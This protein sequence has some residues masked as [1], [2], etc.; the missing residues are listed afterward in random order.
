MITKIKLFVCLLLFYPLTF[1][2]NKFQPA[3]FSKHYSQLKPSFWAV[4][5]KQAHLSFDFFVIVKSHFEPTQEEALGQVQKQ[6]A[7]LFGTLDRQVKRAVPKNNHTVK[8]TKVEKLAQKTFKIQ[9][10]YVGTIQ[11]E[12]ANRLYSF[13]LPLNPDEV[14]VKSLV[15]KNYVT[16]HPC[17]DDSHPDQRY[18]W[19]FFNPRG[20]GCP[21]T[22]GVDYQK[23]TGSLTFLEST[24][25]TYP[26]YDRLI[27]NGKIEIQIFYG[28]DNPQLTHVPEKSKDY[29]A[30]N[31]LAMKKYLLAK[32]YD[33]K[34]LQNGSYENPYVEEFILQTS[35]AQLVV[36]LFFGGTDIYSG[37][38]F[39][40]AWEQSLAQS[41]VVIYAGHSGL[42]S[43]LDLKQIE[44]AS[45]VNLKMPQDQYQILFMNGCS[46][47]PYYA[48]PYF[49]LK[50][51]SKNLDILTNG[52][53]TL[54]VAI[55]S[56]NKALLKAIENF[57]IN[58]H[59]AS[60]QE[61][62]S[63]GDSYNMLAVNGDEDNL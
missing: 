30:S 7:F 33:S 9:Y 49:A 23:V 37:S 32:G 35:K 45:N 14:Y 5:S 34:I 44:T 36:R 3:F 48:D 16:S 27:S 6:V 1:A 38:F 11:T 55:D 22:E 58:G 24:R 59:K 26:E 57:A 41:S 18:F 10:S 46:S 51:G 56:S 19:Y 13:D 61:I 29:N 2:Q 28:M 4:E 53:A 40:K 50:G 39:H 25:S 43:Y 21:L 20:S 52:L 54:F 62:I 60:Y 8:I 12:N 63:A 42:G 31:Y 17:G 15:V 47:Y